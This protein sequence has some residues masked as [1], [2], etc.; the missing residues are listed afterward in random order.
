[1]S[2]APD[3][4]ENVMRFEFESDLI[5]AAARLEAGL[6]GMV[7]VVVSPPHDD[8]KR[9]AVTAGPGWRLLG[10]AKH[11]GGAR[12][13]STRAATSEIEWRELKKLTRLTNPVGSVEFRKEI[14]LAFA[15][16]LGCSELQLDEIVIDQSLQSI[17]PKFWQAGSPRMMCASPYVGYEV[18]VVAVDRKALPPNPITVPDH[19]WA[20]D[21]RSSTYCPRGLVIPRR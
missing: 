14:V 21:R 15:A 4:I 11:E 19:P 12:E 10:R 2:S 17:T 6:G 3:V 7:K 20:D 1:L 8:S 18:F 13:K 9:V 5:D 16:S